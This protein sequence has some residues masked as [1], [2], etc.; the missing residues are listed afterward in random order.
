VERESTYYEKQSEGTATLVR[1]LGGAVVI[2][3]SI[4]ASIGATITMYAAVAQRRREVGT[5]RALGFSR[6]A[7][8]GSFLIESLLLALLGGSVGALCSLAMGQLELTMVNFSTLSE[9][10]F[11]FH[12]TARMLAGSLAVG[13]LMGLAGGLLPAV[14]AAR[15]S[16]VEAMREA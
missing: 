5:L 14:H 11:A 9:M 16:P 1:F 8:L 10:T 13:V 2:F 15:V 6:S 7:I 4:G 12:A 3:F